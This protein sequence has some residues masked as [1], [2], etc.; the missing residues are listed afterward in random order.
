MRL[1]ILALAAALAVLPRLAAAQTA[2]APADSASSAAGAAVPEVE[3]SQL[4][5]PLHPASRAAFRALIQR[6]FPRSLM[7]GGVPLA[8]ARVRMLVDENGTVLSA[9]IEHSSGNDEADRSALEVA[10][11]LRFTAP[12]LNGLPVRV[13]GVMPVVFMTESHPDPSS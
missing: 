11:R 13:R 1:S 3:E 6:W 12:R 8:E 2:P 9:A 5:T 4:A 10:R 7:R